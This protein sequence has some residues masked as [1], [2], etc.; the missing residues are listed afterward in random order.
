MASLKH[1]WGSVMRSALKVLFVPIMLLGFN[2]AAVCMAMAHLSLFWLA[3]LLAAA[4]VFA[5]AVERIVPYQP[6]WNEARGEFGRDLI[7]ALVNVAIIIFL[8]L[9]IRPG[10][11]L[12]PRAL[13]FW[14]QFLLAVLAAD[15]G[16]TF[17]HVLSHRVAWLWR[18]HATHHA[19]THMYGLNGLL[20][21]PAH[22]AFEIIVGGGLLIMLGM[23]HEIGLLVGFAV[24][25]Q[26][27]LQHS[28]ADMKIGPLVWLLNVGPVHRRHHL[29]EFE[30]HGVNF[31]LFTN[32]WD[33][34]MGTFDLGRQAPVGRDEV[35]IADPDYPKTYLAQLR[36]PFARE[37]ERARE[38]AREAAR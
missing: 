5:T 1:G 13:P 3:P 9:V 31:G 19:A 8:V 23:P 20:Q 18:I 10:H 15:A 2:G 11:A 12:W 27:V 38:E 30:A 33:Y 21:H 29:R 16:L 17:A 4:I 22:Q 32:L 6:A 7:H 28:N 36:Q 37:P 34:L 26:F 25:V 24:V 14:A 35:G